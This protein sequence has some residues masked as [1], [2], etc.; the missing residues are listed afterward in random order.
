MK[1]KT[2]TR[3]YFRFEVSFLRNTLFQTILVEGGQQHSDLMQ[4]LK[5]GTL[6]TERWSAVDDRFNTVTA[7][8]V[9]W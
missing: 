5:D 7:D 1:A 8:Q 4:Q 3:M 6:D 2:K 9:K